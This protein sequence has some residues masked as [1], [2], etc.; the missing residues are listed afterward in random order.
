[1]RRRIMRRR[2]ARIVLTLVGS[3]ISA[4]LLSAQRKNAR[5]GT[6]APQDYI[7]IQ[8]LFARYANTTDLERDDGSS[9]A[10]LF[11][12]DATNIGG[13]MDRTAPLS[14][15]G[16]IGHEAL[17]KLI[18]GAWERGTTRHSFTNLLITPTPEGADV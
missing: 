14:G 5:P 11:T 8:Q 6:L 9:Y 3:L 15:R 12:E 4:P 7:D 17:K 1:M 2:C 18:T 10:S 13:T 16:S